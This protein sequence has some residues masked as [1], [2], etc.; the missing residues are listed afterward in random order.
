MLGLHVWAVC[1]LLMLLKWFVQ[2]KVWP[3]AVT[4]CLCGQNRQSWASL[5]GQ[6]VSKVPSPV[7]G[8]QCLTASSKTVPA[9]PV[10]GY[11]FSGWLL[12]ICSESL[13]GAAFA[14]N[15]FDVLRQKVFK[16]LATSV[17]FPMM[18]RN[19]HVDRRGT[20]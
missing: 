11:R 18:R 5:S 2:G 20:A 13:S 3:H 7:C 6:V 17:A 8:G 14:D 12:D 19:W 10:L 1:N 9:P 4:P 16:R 15:H